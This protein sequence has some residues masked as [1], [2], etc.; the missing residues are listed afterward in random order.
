MPYNWTNLDLV[1]SVVMQDEY[2]IQLRVRGDDQ[3]GRVLDPLC[4][5]L[6]S[7]FLHLYVVEFP[8]PQHSAD[9]DT[10]TTLMKFEGESPLPPT[11][12]T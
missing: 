6:P 12:N 9:T 4:Q 10:V 3:I 8:I 5:R 11:A 7:V 1:V 2:S